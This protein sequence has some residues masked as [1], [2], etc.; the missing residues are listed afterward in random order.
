MPYNI[1]AVVLSVLIIYLFASIPVAKRRRKEEEE[2]PLNE[3][4]IESLSDS[5]I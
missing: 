2:I 1:V 3:F 4:S 5:E